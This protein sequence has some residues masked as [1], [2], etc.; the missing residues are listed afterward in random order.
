MNKYSSLILCILT[1]TLYKEPLFKKSLSFESTFVSLMS[2]S[3]LI[4][5]I[6]L[7]AYYKIIFVC[8]LSNFLF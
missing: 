5:F 1:E 4:E 3:R 8:I 6:K 2:T 7:F